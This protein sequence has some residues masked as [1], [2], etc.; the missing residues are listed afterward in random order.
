MSRPALSR[1]LLLVAVGV[2]G[3]LATAT[4]GAE[5][6]DA[7]D[8]AQSVRELNSAPLATD[9]EAWVAPGEVARIDV[10]ANDTDFDGDELVIDSVMAPSAGTASIDEGVVAFIAPD[11]EGPVTVQY[12]VVDGACG[13]D[14][15]S[16]RITVAEDEEP[17]DRADPPTPV[18]SVPDYTG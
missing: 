14:V 9:D 1:T 11:E 2:V 5:G 16:I 4:V 13:A 6:E 12:R 18:T 8:P 15:A 7:C 10:L 3:S 17:V